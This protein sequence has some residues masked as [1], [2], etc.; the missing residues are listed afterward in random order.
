MSDTP[1]IAPA[2]SAEEWRRALDNEFVMQDMAKRFAT[3]REGTTAGM[4]ALLNAMMR[5][6]DPRKI[7]RERV[8]LLRKAAEMIEIE[9]DARDNESYEVVTLRAFAD[10]LASYLPPEA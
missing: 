7:T 1:K 8:D 10:A 5:D 2:L 3:G 6:D 4:I 9:Y